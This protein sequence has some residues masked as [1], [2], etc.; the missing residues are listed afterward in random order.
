MPS[1][2]EKYEKIIDSL[3]NM[4]RRVLIDE[5]VLSQLRD[6]MR[7]LE[8]ENAAEKLISPEMQHSLALFHMS[9]IEVE[10]LILKE[11]VTQAD[12]PTRSPLECIRKATESLNV[13]ARHL[14]DSHIRAE[15]ILDDISVQISGKLLKQERKEQIRQDNYPDMIGVLSTGNS[16]HASPRSRGRSNTTN[17]ES[18]KK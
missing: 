12:F 6:R 16:R 13:V 9:L 17:T 14:R 7:N 1:Y 8:E 4:E 3:N 18:S 5:I 2:K 15:A 11:K 10:D